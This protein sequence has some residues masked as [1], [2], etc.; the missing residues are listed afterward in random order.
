MNERSC[1]N[2]F[3]LHELY[4]IYIQLNTPSRPSFAASS[5]SHTLP[6]LNPFPC[7][8][9]FSQHLQR[10][11]ITDNGMLTMSNVNCRWDT[12]S[13]SGFVGDSYR[14]W[15]N[16]AIH[17]FKPPPHVK[18]QWHAQLLRS[19]DTRIPCKSNVVGCAY[20]NNLI[21]ERS[22]TFCLNWPQNCF[23]SDSHSSATESTPSL[24]KL[25]L[26][27][28]LGGSYNFGS[29]AL[30]WTHRDRPGD[31][32]DLITG[33][34]YNILTFVNGSGALLPGLISDCAN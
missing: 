6:Q 32:W 25:P 11:A 9:S 4:T 3:I 31:W 2:M 7:K 21:T 1:W 16:P 5:S 30:H 15:G 33:R 20:Y 23:L 19:A 28:A 24:H 26:R 34:G 27:L 22:F 29:V 18:F 17:S 12:F 10:R 8:H 13:F 14:S